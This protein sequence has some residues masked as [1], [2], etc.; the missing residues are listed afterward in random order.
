[1]NNG[2]K[3]GLKTNESSSIKHIIHKKKSRSHL[4]IKHLKTQRTQNEVRGKEKRAKVRKRRKRSQ[5]DQINGGLTADSDD[6]SGR[7][8]ER[9]IDDLLSDDNF[10]PRYQEKHLSDMRTVFR[11]SLN[12]NG[13]TSTLEK[14]AIEQY[15]NVDDAG[16][17]NINFLEVQ[18]RQQYES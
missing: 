1:M 3:D 8:I 16:D 5:Q 7:I 13:S 10:S 4:A 15:E 12:R 14:E 9:N 6:E 17:V 18:A 2:S 11:K